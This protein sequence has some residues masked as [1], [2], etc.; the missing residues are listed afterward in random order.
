[1]KA[2]DEDVVL[3]PDNPITEGIEMVLL[4]KDGTMSH[5]QTLAMASGV[6]ASKKEI[7]RTSHKAGNSVDPKSDTSS[8]WWTGIVVTGC[9]MPPLQKQMKLK[10]ESSETKSVEAPII[11]STPLHIVQREEKKKAVQKKG[12]TVAIVIPMLQRIAKDVPDYIMPSEDW[13]KCM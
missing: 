4:Q 10:E 2:I 9:A 11:K 1:M 12:L 7:A 13:M 3:A 6:Q 5:E 8:P